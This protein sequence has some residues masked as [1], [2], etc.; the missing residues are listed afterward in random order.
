[1]QDPDGKIRRHLLSVRDHHGKTTMTLGTKLALAYLEAKNIKLE[2]GKDGVL[3]LG[4]ANFL[5]LEESAGGYVNADVG[6]YQ[7]LSNF[8]RTLAG[9]PK[10]SIS[11]VL[12]D[13][14]PANL[15]KG[16]MSLLPQLPK[17]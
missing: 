7:I 11:D 8:Y 3:K 9:Y 1:V 12:Q 14:I 17:V 4:K 16:R 2:A 15:I 10:I 6:G 13:R 5:P